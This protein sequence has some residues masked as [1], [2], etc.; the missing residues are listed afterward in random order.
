[1]EDAYLIK[2]G[3][4]LHGTVVLS[5]AKNIGLKVLIAALMFE[6]KVELNNIPR[7]QDILELIELLKQLG[8]SVEFGDNN[9]VSLDSSNLSVNKVDLLYASKIRASFLLFAPLLY[10]FGK[11]VIPNP[12]G[13]RIGARSIDRVIE[14]LKS[15]GINLQYDSNTGYYTAIMNQ[16]PQGSY[17][18]QKSSHTG[19]ELLI[20]MSVFGSGKITIEN[21][22][23][24][25]E[26]DDLIGF[27]NE[28]G[29][30]I[31]RNGKTITVEG[32][33]N[34]K[35]QKPYTI[36][37]DRVE[38]FTYAVAGIATQGDITISSI[39]EHFITP[40][41]EV[42]NKTGAGVERLPDNNWRFYYKPIKAVDIETS[43]HPGFLTDWQPLFAVLMSQASG[44]SI[45][46]E[47]IFENRF[48]Y[49][50]ELWRLGAKIEYIHHPVE[51]PVSHYFF[52]YDQNKTYQQTI[53]V[54][55]PQNLHGGVLTMADI[56]AGAT[57]AV[58]A[59]VAN[60]ESYL[61]EVQHMERGYEDFEKKIRN[62]GGE[63][64]RI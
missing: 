40:F 53:Q 11:A 7:I 32:V 49:V 50:E 62:L 1:M 41:L 54:T 14:G 8:V 58:A 47:R 12:G 57:L 46:H 64:K 38:A 52:N 56:R 34:L 19:T 43:P 24:E 42:L 63:I 31:T 21:A 27:L 45:I 37:S 3:K 29:A 13:C 44:Q 35:Q 6:G 20:M 22:A 48:S 61:R 18:F 30:K 39:S 5:G 60:G 10:K 17:A 16:K 33:L 55:G 23:Q 51:N 2:G 36:A 15:L 28:G 25:P 9:V 4:P 26:I 59:L